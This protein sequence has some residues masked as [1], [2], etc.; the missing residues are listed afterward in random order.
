[1]TMST[2]FQ[3]GLYKEGSVVVN[4]RSCFTLPWVGFP[5]SFTQCLPALLAFG[6]ILAVLGGYT[7]ITDATT[8]F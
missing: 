4:V 1:M 8:A 7:E 2:G 3:F 5:V 6:R